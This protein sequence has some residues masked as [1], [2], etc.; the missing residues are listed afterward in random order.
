MEDSGATSTARMDRMEATV[1]D[2]QQSSSSGTDVFEELA[3]RDRRATN[4]IIFDVQ[5][6]TDQDKRV[7]DERDLGGLL[8]LFKEIGV[9][10][11]L[12]SVKLARRE[13]VRQ[14]GVA[15][16]LKVVFRCKEDRD[17]VLSSSFKLARAKEVWQKV[18][19]RADLTLKQRNME[20]E[21]EKSTASKNLTRSREEIEEG[22]AWKVVGKRG[23]KVMRLVKLYPEEEVLV[24]GKVQ[25]KE[26]AEQERGQQNRKRGRRQSGSPGGS[27]SP[28][29]RRARILPSPFGDQ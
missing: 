13:G 11:T 17:K 8:Q 21:L 5:E 10:T 14:D 16:P 15:R 9:D 18:S 19:I 27:N 23:E 6:S 7:R 20:R 28:T 29:S 4:V 1:K 26:Q 24:S 22:R 25:L 12:D 3:E 2:V